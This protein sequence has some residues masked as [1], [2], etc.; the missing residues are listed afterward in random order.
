MELEIPK[1]YSGRAHIKLLEFCVEIL[2]IWINIVEYTLDD[3]EFLLSVVPQSTQTHPKE[4]PHHTI[5]KTILQRE[6]EDL[7][8]DNEHLLYSQCLR[9]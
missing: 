4:H 3:E 1:E 5:A 6:L 7:L 8:I 2:S 9:G